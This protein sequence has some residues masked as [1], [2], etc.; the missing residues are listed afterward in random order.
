MSQPHEQAHTQAR[1]CDAE[2]VS[3]ALM[4]QRPSPLRSERGVYGRSRQRG[5]SMEMSLMAFAAGGCTA[6]PLWPLGPLHA[7]RPPAPF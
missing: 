7:E 4:H 2:R 6:Y 1:L 3:H 5:K